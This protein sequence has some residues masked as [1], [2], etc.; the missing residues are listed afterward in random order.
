MAQA[1]KAVF[2]MVLRGNLVTPDGLIEQGWLGIADGRIMAIGDGP[3]PAAR[4]WRDHGQDWQLPGA[5][6]GQVH[7]CSWRG[8]EGI[9]STTRSAIAGGVTTIVDMPYDDPTPLNSAEQLALKADAIS[10]FAHCDVALYGTLSAHQPVSAIRDMA[11]AGV[12][13][14]KISSFETIRLV[15]RAS[16]PIRCW[17]SW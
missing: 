9:E 3:H 17:R 7:A 11:A 4:A 15:F 2:D 10:R 13:A 8:Y 16:N 12:C 6:D 14:I 1:G 5:I